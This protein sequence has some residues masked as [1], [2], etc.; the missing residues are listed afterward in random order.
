MM[1]VIARIK[2]YIHQLMGSEFIIAAASKK[3]DVAVIVIQ[4]LDILKALYKSNNDH[5]KV[6]ALV[7]L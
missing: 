5:L 7:V 1:L 3:K 6:R 4:G 2:E